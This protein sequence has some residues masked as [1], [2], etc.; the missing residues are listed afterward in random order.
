MISLKMLEY[1]GI[2][3]FANNY[4]LYAI[5]NRKIYKNMKYTL[6]HF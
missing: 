2:C 3:G 1:S 4:D 6:K 5:K